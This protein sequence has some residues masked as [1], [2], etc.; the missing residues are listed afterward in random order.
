MEPLPTAVTKLR[1]MVV[2]AD[3]ITQGGGGNEKPILQSNFHHDYN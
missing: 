2:S 1:L 3:A